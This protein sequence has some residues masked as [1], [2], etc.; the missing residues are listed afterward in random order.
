VRDRRAALTARVSRAQAAID[1]HKARAKRRKQEIDRWKR[2]YAA[3]SV[4]PAAVPAAL[5][6]LQQEVAWRATDI[7]AAEAAIAA[8]EA[9][10]WQATGELHHLLDQVEAAARIAP[11]TPPAKDPRLVA[12]RRAREW[13]AVRLAEAR[14]RLDGLLTRAGAS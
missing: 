5:T 3:S 13:A 7:A 2:W 9:E 12:A 6:R 10:K 8:L 1:A 14:H 4:T 11:G